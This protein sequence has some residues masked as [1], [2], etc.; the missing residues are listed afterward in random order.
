[1]YLL[2]WYPALQKICQYQFHLIVFMIIMKSLYSAYVEF[3][4]L[5]CIHISF[6]YLVLVEC[7]HLTPALVRP[8]TVASIP[9]WILFQWLCVCVCVFAL[10][11]RFVCSMISV[12]IICSWVVSSSA[13]ISFHVESTKVNIHIVNGIGKK[14]QRFALVRRFVWNYR[15]LTMYQRFRT[16]AYHY[17][18]CNKIADKMQNN[19]DWRSLL[20]IGVRSLC[21]ALSAFY[22]QFLRSA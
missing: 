4:G 8:T 22:F 6:P 16:R 11:P 1:M 7:V 20:S 10:F 19:G 2:R 13:A 3:L 15:L 14:S 17:K 18:Q 5:Y 12:I 21:I 9:K